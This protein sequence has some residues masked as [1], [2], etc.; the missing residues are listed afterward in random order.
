MKTKM[1]SF[2]ISVILLTTV[3]NAQVFDTI[4]NDFND[5]LK[6]GGDFFTSPLHFNSGDWGNFAITSA[7]VGGSFF[8]DNTTRKLSQ[9]DHT[10]FKDKLFDIDKYYMTT[11]AAITTAG[12]YG[13]GL[14]TKNEDIRRVGVEIGESMVYAGV[15]TVALKSIIGRSRPYTERGHSDFNPFSVSNDKVS[16][17]SGHATVA[18][19]FSTVMAH[20]VDNIYWKVGWFTAAGLVASARMYH[21]QHWVSDVILGAAIGYFAG[22][23][24]VNHP[25][26]NKDVN[27]KSKKKNHLNYSVGLNFRENQP[28]YTLD[29]GYSF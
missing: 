6:V 2:V 7:V 8:L 26:N 13:I 9:Q 28:V 22:R 23:F 11:Y 1:L 16:A 21:D 17:P 15:I 24:V 29:F 3:S 4:G 27:Q 19:A 5:F 25:L 10:N 18:F 14:F 20:Q 12:I